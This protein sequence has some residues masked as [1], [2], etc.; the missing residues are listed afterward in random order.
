MPP[1]TKR[2]SSSDPRHYQIAVL[3]GLLIYGALA[4]DLEVD[5]LIAAIVLGAA[6]GAQA[7]CSRLLFL[8]FDY[9]SP[10][11][12]GLSL[13]LLLRT[14]SFGVAALVGVLAIASKFVIRWRGKHVFNPSAL[15]IVAAIL[16]SDRAWISPGQWGSVAFFGF[17]VAGLG[18]LVVHRAERSDI[19]FAFLLWWGAIVLGRAAWLGDPLAIPMHQLQNGALLLFAFFMISDPKTTPDSRAGRILFAGVVAVGAGLVQFGLY[20]S[21]GPIYSLVALAPLVPLIDRLLPAGR[22]QWR[23]RAREELQPTPADDRARFR[24]PRSGKHR[25]RY[26]PSFASSSAEAVGPRSRENHPD[27]SIFQAATVHERST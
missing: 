14:D 27:S 24:A 22:Y 8:R 23:G 4:L 15:G 9:R 7:A 26:V 16:L 18:M 1:T 20:R 3:V 11:I 10:L 25:G 13:C 17:V 21:N 6:L 2:S 5:P 19:P 12:T